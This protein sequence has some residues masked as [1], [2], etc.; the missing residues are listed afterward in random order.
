MKRSGVATSFSLRK[1]KI[2]CLRKIDSRILFVGI[3]DFSR[4]VTCFINVCFCS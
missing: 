4:I 3:K 2:I 1:M